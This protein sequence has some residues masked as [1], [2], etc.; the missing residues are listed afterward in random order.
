MRWRVQQRLPAL[1]SDAFT[2]FGL[3][4]DNPAVL[5]A[6]RHYFDVY[7]PQVV[8]RQLLSNEAPDWC[9]E[10]AASRLPVV[11]HQHG[12]NLRHLGRVFNLLSE[13]KSVSP[14]QDEVRYSSLR[15]FLLREM[16]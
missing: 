13:T 9:D 11:L 12:I 10:R 8:Q 15:S 6:I 7:L 2:R 3:E 16:T 1:S 4:S 5:E 14:D